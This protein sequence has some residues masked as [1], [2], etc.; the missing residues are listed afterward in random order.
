M[1]VYDNG[2]YQI[3]LD[4]NDSFRLNFQT[5]PDF[6]TSYEIEVR[7]GEK[8][9]DLESLFFDFDLRFPSDYTVTGIKKYFVDWHIEVYENGEQI[10]NYDLDLEDKDVLVEFISKNL[11]D[12]TMWI[13]YV[14]EFRKKHNCNLYLI[15]V[16]HNLYVDTYPFITFLNPQETHPDSLASYYI[17]P[18]DIPRAHIPKEDDEVKTNGPHRY[19]PRWRDV[20][21]FQ[22]ICSSILGLE[23]KPNLKANLKIYKDFK[24]V[25][26]K[27]YVAIAPQATARIKSWNYK[28]P[29]GWQLLVDYLKKKGYE[30]L[31]CNREEEGER[32]FKIPKGVIVKDSDTSI[33]ERVFDIHHAEFFI[34]ISS[35]LYWVAHA[36]GKR[37][38][39]I[40]GH[41][42]GF[43]DG[44]DLK[45][46]RVSLEDNPNICTGCWHDIDIEWEFDSWFCPKHQE[47]DY[48]TE[49]DMTKNS[50]KWECTKRITPQM[51]FE[52]V[53]TVES[54]LKK[55]EVKKENFITLGVNIGH[56]ASAAL[57]IDGE[58]ISNIAE[59][60]ISRIKHDKNENEI[61]KE[62]IK[63]VLNN[64]SIDLPQVDKVVYNGAG[65]GWGIRYVNSQL[66]KFTRLGISENK[67]MY[68]LHHLMHAYSVYYYFDGKEGTA[69]T[70]D[71]G[72]DIGYSWKTYRENFKNATSYQ[73]ENASM[74]G[75][76]GNKFKTLYKHNHHLGKVELG[77]DK[78]GHGLGFFYDQAC[79]LTGIGNDNFSA[80][81]L[82][83]LTSYGDENLFFCEELDFKPQFEE[84]II[85]DNNDF[86]IPK[87]W[88]NNIFP[89]FNIN[90]YYDWRN[91]WYKTDLRDSD[92]KT[93]AQYAAWVQREFERAIMFLVKKAK[94]L[95][96]SDN[97]YL[98]G[99]CFLNS[100]VNQKIMDSNIFKNVH[101]IPS[102]DDTGIAIGCA[103]YGYWSHF[104]NV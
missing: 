93:K 43:S 75:I 102:A 9:S 89:R 91:I 78:L 88:A 60:R 49:V 53:D 58:L 1:V 40:S 23:H 71:N 90:G 82:M 83:G 6:N 70:I 24:R 100:I 14:E 22:E 67:I 7:F 36:L 97:L 38:V 85:I 8:N 42:H 16:N 51:V 41:N 81:K 31:Y 29:E 28:Y 26:D 86:Y 13:P 98:A 92:F 79:H 12:T 103:Y 95:N 48:T 54:K 30:V 77:E 37:C 21:S 63:Y 18:M 2:L 96:P 15:T 104:L 33:E 61:P 68:G 19:L 64:N 20:T 3:N 17:G 4:F 44:N 99:G 5:T 46:E 57:C 56:D 11:G 73:V 52:A 62:S 27:P 55:V 32:G 69:L 34:G 87:D 76:N 101:I 35:G 45:T 25:T 47:D 66:E 80:G 65:E 59:E 39:L 94:V 84:F 72:G 74:Y 10:V 50:R